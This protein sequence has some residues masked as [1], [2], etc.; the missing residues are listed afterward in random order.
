MTNIDCLQK[1]TMYFGVIG[2]RDYIKWRGEKR[3]FWEFLDQQPDGWLSSL[4]Y[5]RRDLPQGKPMIMDCGAWSYKH[6][7]IPPIDAETVV[8]H[9][10]ELVERGAILIAPDHM[11]IDGVDHAWRRKWNSEQA[12][13]FLETCPDGYKP[14]ACIHGQTIEERLE[15]AEFL[16]GL[17]YQHLA[18]GGMASRAGQKSKMISVAK[19]IRTATQ[20]RRLHVLGL[21]SP[22][23]VAAWNE[24]GVDSCDGSSHFK[25]AFTGGAFFQVE[26]GRLAKHLAAR[27]GEPV[28][29]PRCECRACAML[30]HQDTPVDTRRYG[31]NESNMGRAAHNLNMLMVAQDLAIHA[32]GA[33]QHDLFGD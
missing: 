3:P 2:N 9:Y 10:V 33:E 12:K 17:G 26:N 25:Q 32:N 22:D 8:A 30:R 11:L 20:G 7:D 28:S 5:K 16:C 15:H 6:D 14:M 21:S 4:T 23:Y 18:L 29:A 19:E 27:P 31:S 24:I 1:K 13:R